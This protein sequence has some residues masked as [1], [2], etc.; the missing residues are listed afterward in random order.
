MA[1]LTAV[2]SRLLHVD[3]LTECEIVLSEVFHSIPVKRTGDT[4][5]LLESRFTILFTVC[6]FV[7]LFA[8]LFVS[9]LYSPSGAAS[10][11]SSLMVTAH[12]V[13]LRNG[14]QPRP[15]TQGHKEHE[16][17][18]GG[19]LLDLLPLLPIDRRGACQAMCEA[20]VLQTF[21]CIF[22]LHA[23]CPRH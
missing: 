3:F 23:Q 1:A 17:I 10:K 21:T 6:S 22:R 4:S 19:P 8:C 12:I 15:S 16:D 13:L 14:T 5:S 2:F 11:N 9:Y 20:P 7:C 18:R